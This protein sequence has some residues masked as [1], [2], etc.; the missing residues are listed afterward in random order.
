MIEFGHCV[1]LIHDAFLV[2]AAPIVPSID[3]SD[4]G[5]GQGCTTVKV[6]ISTSIEVNVYSEC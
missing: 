3:D 2:A 4:N 5:D 1:L 6:Q